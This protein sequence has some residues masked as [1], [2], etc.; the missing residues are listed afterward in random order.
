VKVA[1]TGGTGFV[2]RA[3]VR[4]LRARGDDVV[5]FSRKPTHEGER[6]WT[7]GIPG[8]WLDTLTDCDGVV[9][10]AGAGLFDE[11]WTE[12]RLREVRSSR[13]DTTR[14]LA[15][16]M[17]RCPAAVL[18]SAS[19][20]GIYGM[21]KDDVVLDETAPLGDDVLAVICKEWEG[22]ADP[23]RKAGV[24]VCHPRVGIVLGPGGGALEE[25][26]PAFRAFVGGPLGDGRQWLSWIDRDDLVA[27]L[28]RLLEDAELAG[29]INATAPEP[30]T[31]N[32]FARALGQALHRPALFHAPS[33][34]LKIALGSGRAEALLTGQRVVPKR[35]LDAGF[36][37]EKPNVAASLDAILR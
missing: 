19:A 14:V 6:A 9:N 12:A 17:A 26:I 15:E 7:P 22:A 30:V 25:M 24:R 32:D 34:A 10:L 4:A 3:L 27:I 16:G 20:V 1:V 35:L 8:P 11:R 28:I 33:F 5:V 37:F 21:R 36:G 13:V 31:M 2:G 18:V 29:T 23:A